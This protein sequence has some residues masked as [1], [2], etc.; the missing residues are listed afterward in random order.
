[1]DAASDTDADMDC[2]HECLT[3]SFPAMHGATG[4]KDWHL[5]SDNVIR[6]ELPKVVEAIDVCT[7]RCGDVRFAL[8]EQLNIPR[9]GLDCH[10]GLSPDAHT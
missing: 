5:V 10:R 1:M 4:D 6:A 9:G 2:D 7:A 3:D 8:E